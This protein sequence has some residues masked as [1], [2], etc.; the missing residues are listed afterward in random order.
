MTTTSHVLDL[1]STFCTYGPYALISILSTSYP[2]WNSARSADPTATTSDATQHKMSAIVSERRPTRAERSMRSSSAVR[3]RRLV[4]TTTF[5]ELPTMPTTHSAAPHTTQ[6]RERNRN[7]VRPRSGVIQ[8]CPGD[9]R[10]PQHTA[11]GSA[12]ALVNKR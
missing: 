11:P 8:V 3:T 1:A 5:I 4:M 7:E 12:H 6:P 9:R 10:R 2:D